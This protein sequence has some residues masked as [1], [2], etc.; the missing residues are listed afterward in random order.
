MTD[1]NVQRI[2]LITRRLDKSKSP[3]E[4]VDE[5]LPTV[6]KKLFARNKQGT[7]FDPATT[8][9][10]TMGSFYFSGSHYDFSPGST[11]YRI[12]RRSVY[13][14]SVDRRN[15]ELTWA[16]RHSRIGTVDQIPLIHGTL[17][18][19][20]RT[21]SLRAVETGG[22]FNPIYT[23]GP[24]TVWVYFTKGRSGRGTARVYSSVEGVIG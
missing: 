6:T 13:V 22:P 7:I 3:W 20:R 9:P 16:L 2:S 1:Q 12:T 18:N 4:Y 10:L 19:Y 23:L 24:G 5:E 21:D 17:I 15:V 11:S 8:D 14:G